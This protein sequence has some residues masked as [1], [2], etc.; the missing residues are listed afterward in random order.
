[1]LIVTK[2]GQAV[3]ALTEAMAAIQPIISILKGSFASFNAI[4]AANP[5]LIVVAAVAALVAAFIY[6]WNNCEEFRNFFINLWQN[7]QNA[8][9][10]AVEAIKNFFLGMWNFIVNVFSGFIGFFKGI[11][12]GIVAIF[13][14]IA[15][16]FGGIFSSAWDGITAAFSSVGSFFSGVWSGITNIFS[17]VGSWFKNVFSGAW[18]G[19]TDAFSAVGNFFKGVWDVVTSPFRGVID[20][21]KEKFIGARNGVTE[22]FNAIGDFFKN[23][24]DR[25]CAPFRK[26]WEM[27][28][29]IGSNLIK[30]LWDG[31]SNSFDWIKNKIAEWVGNVFN[32]IKKLFGIASP[33]KLFRDE[34]GANLALGIGEGFSD[35]IKNVEQEMKN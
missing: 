27:F 31:I 26:A 32:F 13:S 24:W 25:I 4:L 5:I 1:M 35:E 19:I 8:V 28:C 3:K 29:G 9:S 20:W 15:Q 30:G 7:I 33:S 22:P 18:K 23:V 21:F 10:V 34:I 6:L 17:A 2:I 14:G 11:W 16:W 12:D